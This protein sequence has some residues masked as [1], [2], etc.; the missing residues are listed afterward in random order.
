MKRPL[1]CLLPALA[2]TGCISFGDDAPA[3]G[4]GEPDTAAAA[5]AAP[6]PVADVTG[7]EGLIYDGSVLGVW[8]ADALPR[9]RIR[10]ANTGDSV[11]AEETRRTDCCIHFQENNG[12][13][14]VADF[15]RMEVQFGGATLAIGNVVY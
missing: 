4:E 14:M 15:Q 13:S 5:E 2:L 12:A 1:F 8:Q 3:P 6:I 7:F 10:N 11:T 9:W